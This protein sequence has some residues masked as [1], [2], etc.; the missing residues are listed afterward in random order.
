MK[1]LKFLTFVCA[2]FMSVSLTSCLDTDDSGANYEAILQVY[3]DDL[4]GSP[5]FIDAVGNQLFPTSESMA[6]FNQNGYDVTDYEMAIIYFNYVDEPASTQ[7]STTPQTYNIELVAFSP[8]EMLHAEGVQ[9]VEDMETAM[10][11][12][13]PIVTLRQSTGAGTLVPYLFDAKTAIAYT[14]FWLT[15]DEDQYKEHT[16]RLAYVYDEITA[17]SEDLELYVRHDRGEDDGVESYYANYYGFD[18]QGAISYF[19]GVTGKDPNKIIINAKEC[20]MGTLDLP[21]G[22]TSYEIEYETTSSTAE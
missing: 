3:V 8:M 9:T 7:S 15:N 10:P 2:L 16:M 17:T 13:A 6:Y 19:R 5:L 4:Y 1:T 21:E 11:E 12:T 18:L 14:G 20:T 22:Y